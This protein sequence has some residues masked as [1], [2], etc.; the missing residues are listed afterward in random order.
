[1]CN[2][3]IMKSD[4]QISRIWYG[5]IFGALALLLASLSSADSEAETEMDE[6]WLMS[7]REQGL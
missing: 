7:L 4:H 1:M 3:K 6:A 2:R 5:T